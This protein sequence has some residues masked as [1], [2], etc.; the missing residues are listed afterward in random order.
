MAQDLAPPGPNTEH[1]QH[2]EHGVVDQANGMNTGTGHGGKMN[3]RV[4]GAHLELLALHGS[5]R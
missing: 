2:D 5:Q 3:S 4:D 1:G